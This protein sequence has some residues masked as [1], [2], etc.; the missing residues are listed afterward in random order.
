MLN[1]LHVSNIFNFYSRK[2]EIFSKD[3]TAIIP[4]SHPTNNESHIFV[5]R[6]QMVPIIA[7]PANVACLICSTFI[8]YEFE[9]NFDITTADM[10]LAHKANN[11]LKIIYPRASAEYARTEQ[12]LGQN[13][14]KIIVPNNE[15]KL[16]V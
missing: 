12:K 9:R 13:T 4:P 6:S 14:Q 16:L 7:A 11:V 8:F 10:Q 3:K 1:T 5:D 15:N 2:G